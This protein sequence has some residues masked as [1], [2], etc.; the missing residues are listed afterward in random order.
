MGNQINKIIS[1][2]IS[3]MFAH[4]RKFY[5]NA[6]SLSYL[7]PPRTAITGMLA[8][9]LEIPRDEYYDRFSENKIRVSVS[10]PKGLKIRKQTQSMNYLHNKYFNLIAK[11][12]EKGKVQHSQCK[13][14]LLMYP[15]GEK[16]RYKIY[17]GG[18]KNN[19]DFQE[20]ES[21]LKNR[22]TGYGCYL[23]Q[24]QFRAYIEFLDSYSEKDFVFLKESQILDSA[25][26]KD[27]F[28]DYEIKDDLNIIEE[29]MPVAF[30][31]TKSKIKGREP[32]NIKKIYFDRNG[33]RLTGK[34][35]NCYRIDDKYISFY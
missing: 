10:I 11:G 33:N 28:I 22:K 29:Q 35:S 2:E 27:N 12:S 23:G 13:L 16:I 21:K 17:V 14:E 7:I 25:V 20:I 24:R 18:N 3:G 8:S 26:N 19:E 1:F 9:I 30:K 5:T 34:F 31:Q 15:A 32:Q 4:F 6:S